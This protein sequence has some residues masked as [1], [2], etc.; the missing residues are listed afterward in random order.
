MSLD[1][2][3]FVFEDLVV[4]AGFEFA[5]ARG[6]GCD[7]HGCLAAA[8]DDEVLLWG[9]GGGVEGG[10][11]YVGFEEGEVAGGDHLERGMD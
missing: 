10:V 9:N 7:V 3:D 5:L 2:S 6:C 1:S 11:G 4:E 8:K